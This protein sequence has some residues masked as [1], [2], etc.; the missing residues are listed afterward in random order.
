MRTVEGGQARL[1]DLVGPDGMPVALLVR[2]R[3]ES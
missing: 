2:V 1:A 3:D